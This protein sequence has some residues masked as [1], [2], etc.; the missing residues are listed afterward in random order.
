MEKRFLCIA[1]KEC[2]TRLSNR[3]EVDR[4]LRG[5]TGRPSVLAA[6][7]AH[8]FSP[9]SPISNLRVSIYPYSRK[10]VYRRDLGLW[11]NMVTDL[12]YKI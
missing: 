6:R 9:E 10:P 12:I 7:Y 2:Q 1:R 11:I 8:R 4:V 5:R 3:I